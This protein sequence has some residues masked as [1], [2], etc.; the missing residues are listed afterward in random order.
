MS[1]PVPTCSEGESDV[2]R[3][4]S[5]KG[6]RE[7]PRRTLA[8][9]SSPIDMTLWRR[10]L[11]ADGD[12]MAAFHRHRAGAVVGVATLPLMVSG[13]VTDDVLDRNRVLQILGITRSVK[14]VLRNLLKCRKDSIQV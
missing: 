5:F 11:E 7:M 12:Q 1:D 13:N 10:G 4:A 9:V 14:V 2:K 6:Q 8:R 3:R